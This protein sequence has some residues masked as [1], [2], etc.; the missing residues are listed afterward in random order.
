MYDKEGKP[1]ENYQ[2][3]LEDRLL[4]VALSVGGS[5]ENAALTT[6]VLEN[7]QEPRTQDFLF[8]LA[9]NILTYEKIFAENSA[10]AKRFYSTFTLGDFKDKQAAI[11]TLISQMTAFKD[12]VQAEKISIK[13]EIERLGKEADV[14]LTVPN[15][16]LIALQTKED[17]LLRAL[18]LL[19]KEERSFAA[20]QSA[21]TAASL[22]DKVH[23]SE[24]KAEGNN[25]LID[26]ISLDYATQTL[27]VTLKKDIL[28]T[29]ERLEEQ[30]KTAAL[31][32]L[33]QLIFNENHRQSQIAHQNCE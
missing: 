3:L 4:Q 26:T 15:S 6:L 2:A 19:K 12:R 29:R 7:P 14:D 33:N 28:E 9:Q 17:K 8:I 21:W 32:A 18:S 23:A 25:P 27:T 13:E 16:A 24:V 22:Q 10:L 1:S 5:S 31:S 30:N 20:G 11:Q